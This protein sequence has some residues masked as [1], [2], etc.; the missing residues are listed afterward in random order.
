MPRY[1][2]AAAT[3]AWQGTSNDPLVFLLVVPFGFIRGTYLLQET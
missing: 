1:E 2:Q 3:V